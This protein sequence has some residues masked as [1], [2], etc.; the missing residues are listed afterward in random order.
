[1]LGDPSSLSVCR[2]ALESDQLYSRELWTNAAELGWLGADIP[3]E[4]GGAGMGSLVLA[5]PVE[6]GFGASENP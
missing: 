1:M 3:G 4:Y 5:V 6:K 2:T